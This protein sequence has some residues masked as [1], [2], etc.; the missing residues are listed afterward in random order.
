MAYWTYTD[1]QV[2]L[3]Q[4]NEKQLKTF[5][6]NI[7]ALFENDAVH[8]NLIQV[9][10]IGATVIFESDEFKKILADLHIVARAGNYNQA[11][12]EETVAML[13][14]HKKNEFAR[15][16]KTLVIENAIFALNCALTSVLRID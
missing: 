3:K 6:N 8:Q 10:A 11:L 16:N 13:R 14:E 7:V 4:L 12:I 15:D 5:K 1:K 9:L 2:K